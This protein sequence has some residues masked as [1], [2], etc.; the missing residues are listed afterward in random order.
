MQAIARYAAISN[1]QR[2]DA[3]RNGETDSPFKPST[4]APAAA[5]NQFGDNPPATLNNPGT[6]HGTPTQRN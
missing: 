3:N 1:G 2:F 5:N 4:S 6:P